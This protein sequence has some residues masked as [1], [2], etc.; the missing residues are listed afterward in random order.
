MID[1]E[2]GS[3]LK[4]S[5]ALN[6]RFAV[7]DLLYRRELA[8]HGG[9]ALVELGLR[10][11][12]LDG[13]GVALAL[14][15]RQALRALSLPDCFALALAK[16]NSWMLLSGDRHVRQLAANE[17]IACHGVLW[18]VDRIFEQGLLSN[19]DLYTGVRAIAAHPRCRLPRHELLERL[20]R[21]SHH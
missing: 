13:E 14:R 18:V 20:E 3:L 6:Y 5:F 21:F 9:P 2:R 10:I 4:T 17:R 7:P 8:V 19:A 12:E 15:Y 1:L 16:R 11:E